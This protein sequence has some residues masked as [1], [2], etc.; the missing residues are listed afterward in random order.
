MGCCCCC[1]GTRCAESGDPTGSGRD[2]AA[3]PVF[4]P[5]CLRTV[6]APRPSWFRAPLT[7]GFLGDVT[8]GAAMFRG[9]GIIL[10]RDYIFL[11]NILDL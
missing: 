3:S 8:T 11:F 2:Q 5:T 9:E 4:I 6:V 1:A 10:I 7:F